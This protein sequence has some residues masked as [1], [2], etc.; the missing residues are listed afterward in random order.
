VERRVELLIFMCFM[1]FIATKTAPPS[2]PG[3]LPPAG[4]ALLPLSPQYAAVRDKFTLP[5]VSEIK[6]ITGCGCWLRHVDQPDP[7]G[8]EW[9]V[10]EMTAEPNYNPADTQPNHEGL[11]D[12][13]E[14][15][16]RPDGFV[17]F[18]G[19]FAGD[20]SQPARDRKELPVSAI[21]DPKF[22]FHGGTLYRFTFP[23]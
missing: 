23:E 18:F 22:H 8:M 4:T 10:K 3:K 2:I 5:H 6:L 15:H 13:L 16:F 21:R 11:A 7:E 1:P 19:Y 12:Y 20:A 9:T 17:E 14:A